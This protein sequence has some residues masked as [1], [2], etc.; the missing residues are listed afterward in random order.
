MTELQRPPARILQVLASLDRGGAEQLV[1]DWYRQMDRDKVQFDFVVYE[2]DKP[3]D[4]EETVRSMGARVF[5][6]PYPW[7]TGF[8]SSVRHWNRLLR[9]HPEWRVIHAHY[10]ATAPFYFPQARLEGR[11]CIAHG[12]A[13][14]RDIKWPLHLAAF[15]LA[16]TRVA[17]SKQV[18]KR[19]MGPVNSEVLVNGIDPRRFTFDPKSRGVLSGEMGIGDGMLLGH[20]GRFSAQKNHAF[21]LEIFAE[22]LKLEADANLLLVGQGS[23]RSDVEDKAAELGISTRVHLLGLRKDIPDI[24]SGL[25]LLVMPSLFEGMPITMIEAQANGLPCLVS[26]V[27]SEDSIVPEVGTV[28]MLPL[29]ASPKTWARKAIDMAS[30]D[31]GD[32]ATVAE[33]MVGR[34]YDISTSARR[35]LEIYGLQSATLG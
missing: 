26:D 16:N 21:L 8:G 27:V 13:D 19:R 11:R 31:H 14:S 35:L 18:Q 28:E 10:T 25:D 23:L 29:S 20:I 5:K 12:H 24:M 1:L 3:Y 6:V 7:G 34:P 2:R 17:C 32:R 15:T 9:D 4:H 22:V 30:A 33:R